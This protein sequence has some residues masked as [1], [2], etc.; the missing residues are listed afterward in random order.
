[1]IA[2]YYNTILYLHLKH[3]L[4]T[5]AALHNMLRFP[6][7]SYIWLPLVFCPTCS[8]LVQ[9]NMYPWVRNS[10]ARLTTEAIVEMCGSGQLSPLLKQQTT[11]ARQH[12]DLCVFRMLPPSITRQDPPTA[13]HAQSDLNIILLLNNEMFSIAVLSR[14]KSVRDCPPELRWEASGDFEVSL[15]WQQICTEI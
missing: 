13:F 11:S 12:P 5:L 1:M 15:L 2:D 10:R 3:L 9:V 6:A 7:F 14:E 4:K 8:S